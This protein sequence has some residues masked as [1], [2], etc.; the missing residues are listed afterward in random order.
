MEWAAHALNVNGFSGG[1]KHNFDGV[2]GDIVSGMKTDFSCGVI[3]VRLREGRREYLLVQHTAGHWS[4]P[5]GHPEREEAPR[6]TAERELLEETGLRCAMLV[7]RPAFDERYVF[8]KR[9]GTT[10]MKLVTYFVGWIEGEGGGE[11]RLQE[12]EVADAAWGDAAQT[13]GRMT[14]AEGCALLSEVEAFLD[15]AGDTASTV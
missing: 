11:L 10:V 9:S 14:F 2:G 3:P 1:R 6:E 4:F 8:K 12:A 5:K 7:E 13:A 15:A